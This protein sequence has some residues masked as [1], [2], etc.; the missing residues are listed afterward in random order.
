MIELNKKNELTAI[1]HIMQQLDL[2][3]ENYNLFDFNLNISEPELSKDK[4]NFLVGGR[5]NLVYN[6]NTQNYF[7]V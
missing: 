5:I 7:D 3:A 1:E 6:Q 2:M 4:K